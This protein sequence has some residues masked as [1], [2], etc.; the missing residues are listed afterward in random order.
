[1]TTQIAA[2]LYP[3]TLSVAC[4]NSNLRNVVLKHFVVKYL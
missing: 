4:Y 2:E 1:M 3:V